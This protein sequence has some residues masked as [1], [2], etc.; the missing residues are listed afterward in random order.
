MFERLKF[1]KK[2]DSV[3]TLK[4]PSSSSSATV[5]SPEPTPTATDALVRSDSNSSGSSSGSVQSHS[6][7]THQ[8]YHKASLTSLNNAMLNNDTNSA[9]DATTTTAT[10]TTAY[11]HDHNS[12]TNSTSNSYKVPLEDAE[13][14]IKVPILFDTVERVRSHTFNS[15]GSY[16][17]NP[18][19]IASYGSNSSLGRTM[20]VSSPGING[21]I[22][23]D[24]SNSNMVP[25]TS[26]PALVGNEGCDSNSRR[27]S[28]QG[29]KTNAAT[30][31]AVGTF[32]AATVTATPISALSNLGAT[33][34][35]SNTHNNHTSPGSADSSAT[36]SRSSSTSNKGVGFFTPVSATPPMTPQLI[37][38]TPLLQSPSNN[39]LI[40]DPTTSASAA[41]SSHFE[42]PGHALTR[43]RDRPLHHQYPMHTQPPAFNQ[44]QQHMESSGIASV[45][46]PVVFS[47]ASTISSTAA[48]VAA[49][50]MGHH[51][52]MPVIYGQPSM[53]EEDAISS[54]MAYV[55]SPIS[56]QPPVN[57]LS[58]FQQH[59]PFLQDAFQYQ[60]MSAI[61][62]AIGT[63]N[64][65]ATTVGVHVQKEDGLSRSNSA[66]QPNIAASRDGTLLQQS[67][68]FGEDM[69]R[70][71]SYKPINNSSSFAGDGSL[72]QQQQQQ[73]QSQE[74]QSSPSLHPSPG[75]SVYVDPAVPS[76]SSPPPALLKDPA[77]PTPSIVSLGSQTLISRQDEEDQ[78]QQQRLRDRMMSAESIGSPIAVQQQQHHQQQ[79]TTFNTT[80][81]PSA[82]ESPA[83]NG[84]GTGHGAHPAPIVHPK[85]QALGHTGLASVGGSGAGSNFFPSPVTRASTSLAASHL[86]THDIRQKTEGSHI[87]H[88]SG[89]VVLMAIGKTGQGKSSLLNKIMGTSE[90]KAS[91]SVRAVTKGIAERTGWG[92]F[93][94][95]RRVLVTLADT[96]GLADTEG[97][98]EKNIPILKEYIRS[99]GARIGVTAFLLVFKIDSGVD[100]VMTILS[101]FNDIMKEFPDFW[102]NVVLVFT[103]CDYRRDVMNTK[104]L[105]HEEIQAQLQQH[106]FKDLYSNSNGS[107]PEVVQGTISEPIVP[108]VFLSCAEAPCGFA[109]GEKCDCKAR[110]TVLKGGIK[111]LWYAVRNKKRWVIDEDDDDDLLGHP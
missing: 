12:R 90:L 102:N 31:P 51:Q 101:T 110:T 35:N 53:T 45:L 43:S 44:L 42:H 60:Y 91:A 98:D 94:D 79:R 59:A 97:D 38:D 67:A 9:G 95:S 24:S 63:S 54:S 37:H 88:G 66:T 105:Y 106:F 40:N 111:R 68:Q 30:K 29:P 70:S 52:Q 26:V 80:T 81:L 13:D 7:P 8:L 5:A 1:K 21:S 83:V 56:L 107:A 109:L 41:G 50:S 19:T 93:E 75:K 104:Q 49:L 84:T 14:K 4:P 86:I 64:A 34:T 69:N 87:V 15:Y 11:A 32:A 76:T 103:G 22:N 6:M 72:Q 3:A 74:Q 71:S 99:V 85:A 82:T 62:S 55:S 89:P 33:N 92:R 36:P 27:S 23:N 61:S 96:P 57:P 100:M 16:A 48:P 17:T 25:S 58:S 78:L 20:H 28:S 77:Q 47:T 46:S 10:D 65:V 108:M 39:S 2:T 18:T 73:P